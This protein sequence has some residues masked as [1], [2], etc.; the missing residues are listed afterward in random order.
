ML[1]HVLLREHSILS[2]LH[3][4]KDLNYLCF[5]WLVLED[6]FAHHFDVVF[7]L[8]N[9]QLVILVGIKHLPEL[10]DLFDKV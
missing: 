4:L 8:L 10:F 1:E 5:T 9:V 6:L 2:F 7:G 3:L